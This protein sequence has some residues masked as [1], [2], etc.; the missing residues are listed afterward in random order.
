MPR[1]KTNTLKRNTKVA[2]S[3]LSLSKHKNLDKL[4]LLQ[5][6]QSKLELNMSYVNLVLG[7][8]IVLVAGILVFNYFKK[9]QP[10]LGPAG[11]TIAEKELAKANAANKYIVKEG[12]TLFTIAENLYKDGYKYLAL[13]AANKIT[14]VNI[15]SVG[16]VLDVPKLENTESLGTGGATNSTIWGDKIEGETYTVVEGDWLSTIAG[17]AYNDIMAFEKIAKANNISNADIIEPGTVLK[18]PR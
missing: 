14:D 16:Q 2:A 4:S 3:T 12:D 7:L 10:D 11:Q 1:A 5:R 18:I 13:A 17:R 8:L 15:I 9:T 6:L